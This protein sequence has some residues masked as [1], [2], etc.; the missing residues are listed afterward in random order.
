VRSI[1]VVN[2]KGG[3]GKT[4]TAL[5]LAVAA[6]MRDLR[7][8][9][10]DADPQANASMTLLDGQAVEAPT[11]GHVLL[12]Q[13]GAAEASRTT[14]VEGVD[15][16]PSDAG[17]A[18][19]TLLLSDQLGRERRLRPAMA[20]I[21]GDYDLV[22][23]DAAPTLNLVTINVLNYV[24]ELVVPVDAGLYSVAGL[25]RLRDAVDQVRRYLDNR[26]L[27]IAGL[28]LTRAHNNRA[29]RDIEA[30][31]REAFGPQVY[32][33]V[34][35]HSVRVEEAHARHRTVL[36]F[37]PRSAPAMAYDRLATEVFGHGESAGNPEPAIDAD[38]ADAA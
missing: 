31:L 25:G 20:P 22:I 2:L 38:E 12:G 23:V 30:Q 28:V 6:A 9:L 5:S 15:V 36:E 27:R 24:A 3:S 13:A 35:P 37:A 17:L 16:L 34:I 4:T 7:V 32:K 14:R 18:D 11:L 1:G 26:D 33:A 29:T 21:E 10:I 8:L 19:A